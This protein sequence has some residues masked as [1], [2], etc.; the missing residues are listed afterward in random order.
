MHNEHHR[1]T[2]VTGRSACNKLTSL[3]FSGNPVTDLADPLKVT[4][5][6]GTQEMRLSLVPNFEVG[7]D[8]TPGDYR[9]WFIPSCPLSPCPRRHCPC[10]PLS[11]SSQ[12]VF[13]V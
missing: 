3:E 2:A 9:A 4:V 10:Y 5:K 11:K 7:G 8:G 12:L 6:T 13:P 1:P